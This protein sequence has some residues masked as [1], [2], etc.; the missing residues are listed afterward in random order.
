LY[1]N[2]TNLVSHLSGLHREPAAIAHHLEQA[3]ESQVRHHVPGT[4]EWSRASI[5]RHIMHGNAFK[6]V[7]DDSITSMLTALITKQ[8]KSLVDT[9]S[10][11][12]VDEHRKSFCHTV[13]LYMKWMNRKEGPVSKKRK[14]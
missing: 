11:L 2:L 5:L 8:N 1:G 4:P 13:E 9:T 10:D 6:S 14:R 7:F 3:Y 12:V